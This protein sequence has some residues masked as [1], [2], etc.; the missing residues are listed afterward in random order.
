M[1]KFKNINKLYWFNHNEVKKMKIDTIK[2]EQISLVAEIQNSDNSNSN[3]R[4]TLVVAINNAVANSGFNLTYK[5]KNGLIRDFK[6]I[7]KISSKDRNG[8]VNAY[9]EWLGVDGLEE[10]ASQSDSGKAKRRI[11]KDAFNVAMATIKE[12]AILPVEKTPKKKQFTGSNNAKIWVDGKF[13]EDN[14]KKLNILGNDKVAL[15]FSE[16]NRVAKKYYSESGLSD[17]LS[18]DNSFTASIQKITRMINADKD[19]DCKSNQANTR[20][21][22]VQLAKACNDWCGHLRF[23]QDKNTTPEQLQKRKQSA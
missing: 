13:V 3:M 16:L 7:N 19:D 21:V 9:I 17:E 22:I 23:L 5:D 1:I 6:K 14:E 4:L 15:N 8:F 12:N 2:K 20:N 18:K 11:L 10:W